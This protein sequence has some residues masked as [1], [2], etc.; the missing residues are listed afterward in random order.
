VPQQIIQRAALAIPGKPG[1]L[2]V[3]F[4]EAAPF[5]YATDAR[6]YLFDQ[7]LQLVQ[8]GTSNTPEHRH[9]SAIGH[10]IS[11]IHPSPHEWLVRTL[12]VGKGERRGA[13]SVFDC[14]AVIWVQSETA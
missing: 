9:A 12:F 6:G 11:Q 2:D 1:V 10:V 8:A 7:H 4:D 5:Q 13:T 3:A 14:Y